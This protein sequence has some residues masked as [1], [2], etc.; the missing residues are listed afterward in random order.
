[1]KSTMASRSVRLLPVFLALLL[2][3]ACTLVIVSGP[4]QVVAGTSVSY[5]LEVSGAGAGFNT[6]YVVAYVPDGWNL[7]SS[8]YTGTADGAPIAGSGTV[9]GSGACGFQPAIGGYQQIRLEAGPFTTSSSDTAEATL[10][11]FVDSQ[12]E[13]QYQIYFDFGTD[14]Q[15]SNYV[16]KV[17]N[18]AG[19]LRVLDLL[20]NDGQNDG[21]DGEGVLAI[22]PGGDHLYTT[23]ADQDSVS[24]YQRDPASG[25]LGF[26]ETL[27]SPGR[28]SELA[29]THDGELLFL[30]DEESRAIWSYAVDPADGALELLEVVTVGSGDG[31]PRGLAVSPDDRHLYVASHDSLDVEDPGVAMF[32]IARDGPQPRLGQIGFEPGPAPCCSSGV[33]V[34]SDGATLYSGQ[35]HTVAVYARDPLTGGLELL[36]SHTDGVAG[37]FGTRAVKF[38]LETPDGRHLIVSSP[39]DLGAGLAVFERAADGRLTFH[40]ALLSGVDLPPFTMGG[41]LTTVG[42]RHILMRGDGL[43]WLERDPDTGDVSYELALFGR[44]ADIPELRNVNRILESGDDFTSHVYLRTDEGV[45]AVYDSSRGIFTDG[46]ESGDT[47]SWSSTTP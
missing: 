18:A 15:C 19:L 47:S 45:L 40:D 23:S 24:T 14:D 30:L 11:F 25:A 6:Y 5:V 10:E 43:T 36:E 37:V 12:P 26:T 33:L 46:F 3:G 44:G 21:L 38:F 20:T 1:M 7:T 27:V 9:V 22:A 17:I 41:N 42:D 29:P 4:S 16:P 28:P 35:E 13:G 39:F 2:S 31:L 34:S 32:E 8:S